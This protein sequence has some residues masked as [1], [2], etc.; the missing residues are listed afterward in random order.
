MKSVVSERGQMVIPK[1]FRD[2]LGLRA[3]QEVECLE[4]KGRLVVLKAASKQGVDEVYGVLAV[5]RGSDEILRDLRG[6]APRRGRR[7]TTTK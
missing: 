5:D 1:K 7:R 6:A 2:R 3:G 4:E